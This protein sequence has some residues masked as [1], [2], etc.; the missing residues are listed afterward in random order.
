MIASYTQYIDEEN[1]DNLLALW[2]AG[3]VIAV[4]TETVY[5]L[6]ADA[7]SGEAVARI[8]ALKSRPQFNPLI[9]HVA[10]STMAQ[11]YGEWNPLAERFAAAFW[12]G[13]LTLVLKRLP[14]C[15]VSA[16]ASAGGETIALRVP[17]HKLF[18]KLIAAY[19]EGIAAPSANRSG[20]ISPTTAAH[21]REEFA[22]IALTVV[23]GGA[24]RIGLES[25]VVDVADGGHWRILRPGA[26]TAEMLAAA[27]PEY[28][29]AQAS[30][31]AIEAGGTHRS[32]GQ[33]ES[34]YAPS[35]PVR[36]NA[37]DVAADEALLAFGPSP[38]MGAATTLNLSPRGDLIE[39]AANLFAHLRALDAPSHRAIAVMPIPQQGIGIAIYDRLQRASVG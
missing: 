12:P 19:G 21:V 22:G 4:P 6:A 10:D 8:Y 5:G 27:A 3:G 11:R 34:H 18:H 15:A 37:A 25:T 29:Q 30:D 35:I 9:V 20:R 23:E 13:P 38:L 7:T 26:I 2:R 28:S 16:L 1:V 36:L 32:P 24:A 14:N 17:A 39:A 33:M 31:T